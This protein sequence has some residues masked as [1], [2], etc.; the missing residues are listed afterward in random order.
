MKTLVLS[1]I[2]AWGFHSA[3]AGPEQIIKQRAKDIRDQN[4]AQQGVPAASAKPVAGP[5]STAIAAV[6]AQPPLAQMNSEILTLK[7][8]TAV[9]AAQIQQF[10]R[11]LAAAVQGATKP[12]DG[13]LQKLSKDLL[14]ALSEKPLNSNLRARLLQNLMAV[15]NG[16]GLTAGQVKNIVADIQGVLQMGGTSADRAKVVA[17][18]AQVISAEIRK[19]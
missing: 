14:S 18:D 3:W 1:V 5:A 19:S 11:S 4:N 10:A 6:P 13:S 17:D 12:T 9:T 16:P 15:L 2:V 8:N 7:T